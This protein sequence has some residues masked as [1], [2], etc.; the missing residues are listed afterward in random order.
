[1]IGIFGDSYADL[2]PAQYI[3]EPLGRMPWPMW[4]KQFSGKKIECHVVSA[5][6]IWYSYKKFLANYKNYDTIVFCYSDL[7]RWPNINDPEGLHTGL[8]HIR[9]R[10]QLKI[11][12]PEYKQKAGILVNAYELLHDWD[13]DKFIFQ[14]V[15]DSVNNLCDEFGIKVINVLNFEEINDTALAIDITKTRNTV[16][17]NLVQ[18]SI[19]EHC[20]DKTTLIRKQIFNLITENQDKRF[21]HLSPFNNKILAEIVYNCINNDVR[22]I[23]LGKDDRFS[24][25]IEHLRYL[26]YLE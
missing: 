12:P 14:S 19:N 24:Y 8:H 7:H 25:D 9:H 13:L 23:N 1:M 6:S 5:T 4:V 21:C 26:L 16:L 3:N 22:Y 15:F 10:E 18:I 20:N 17:T 11:V 2:N